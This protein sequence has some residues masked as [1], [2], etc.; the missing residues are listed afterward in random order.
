M[1]TTP[2]SLGNIILLKEKGGMRESIPRQVDKKSRGPQ[3]ERGSG[4]LKEEER[5]NFFVPLY[6]LELCN[7]NVSCLST[8]SGRNLLAN[9]VILRCKLWE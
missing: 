3:G 6:S 2:L 1:K 5:A 9:P 8:V 7:N 4:I